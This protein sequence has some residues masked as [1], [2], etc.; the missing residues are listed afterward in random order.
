VD[1]QSGSF[2]RA[3]SRAKEGQQMPK[4]KRDYKAEYARRI[5]RGLA[6]GLTRAQA[7]GH[8]A[9]AQALASNPTS[10]APYD[11][12]LEVGFRWIKDGKSL[13]AAAKEAHVS[14]ERLRRYVQGQRIAERRGRRWVALPDTRRRRVLMYSEGRALT[15]TVDL[16]GAQEVGA[17]MS[18]VGNFLESNDTGYLTWFER[19]WVEDIRGR[20]H[21]FET[22]PNTLYRLAHTGD[23]TFEQVYRIVMT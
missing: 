11:P 10:I 6:K 13:S 9:P 3:E 14:P 15:V 23:E 18:S 4:R 17:Y 2:R 22:D 1:S 21:P 19:G 16:S 5:G 20:R 12:R 8:P 7:R